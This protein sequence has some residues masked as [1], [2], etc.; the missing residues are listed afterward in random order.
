MQYG[1]LLE[2]AQGEK[3]SLN[4]DPNQLDPEDRALLMN[5]LD[6][7]DSKTSR[8]RPIVPW[9]RRTEYIS[10]DSKQYG[11]LADNSVETKMGISIMKDDKLKTI[12]SQTIQD[13]IE[14]IEESFVKAA[15]V[16]LATLKHPSDPNLTAMEMVPIFPDFEFWPNEYT[17]ASY[18]EDPLVKADDAQHDDKLESSILKPLVNPTDQSMFLAYYTPTDDTLTKLAEKRSR[19][20]EFGE[21]D[22]DQN[23]ID[24]D[25][26]IPLSIPT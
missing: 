9:L 10:S 17:L 2:A 11:R 26:G 5:P 25:L 22:D 20:N 18:D 7:K 24:I 21:D 8:P 14:A 23:V 4:T 12:M 16:N 3:G 1:Y 15:K 6:V 19:Y 13:R